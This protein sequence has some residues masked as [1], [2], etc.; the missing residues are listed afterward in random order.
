MAS[1][2]YS[3]FSAN[4]VENPGWDTSK[5]SQSRLVLSF[6]FTRLEAPAYE[7]TY[8]RP[9]WAWTATAFVE[10]VFIMPHGYHNQASE[11]AQSRDSFMCEDSDQSLHVEAAEEVDG[12]G[13]ESS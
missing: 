4:D 11:A 5:A 3:A 10:V 7:T 6:L 13:E 2:S 9:S 8:Q 12:G 1:E